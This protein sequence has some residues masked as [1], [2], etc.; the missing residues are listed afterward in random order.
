M[1]WPLVHYVTLENPPTFEFYYSFP[2]LVS[3]TTLRLFSLLM[4][5][6]RVGLC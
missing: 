4:L 1:G 5:C 3:E 6:V 2:W